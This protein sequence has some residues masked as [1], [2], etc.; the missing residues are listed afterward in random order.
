MARVFDVDP[1]A[2]KREIFH[3]DHTNDTSYI[4][5]VQDVTAIA[6]ENKS[7][8]AMV[9][10]RAGWKGDWHRVASIP[11]AVIVDLNNKGILRGYH[12]VDER[13]FK[14]WLNDGDNKVFRT[15][16]GRI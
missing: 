7:L 13:A 15:R 5:T 14:R 16:P 11:D 12:C 1:A 8:H 4:E 10:E 9:D 3:Y 2:K 6:E